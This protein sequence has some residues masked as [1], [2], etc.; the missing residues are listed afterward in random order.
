MFIIISTATSLLAGNLQNGD[1]EKMKADNLRNSG[2]V[3]SP[4]MLVFGPDVI[5]NNLT[6][7]QSDVKIATAF[8]GWIYA[9]YTCNYGTTGAGIHLMK[10]TDHGQTWTDILSYSGDYYR[11]G[12]A[13][14]GND[15]N[16]MNVYLSSVL[17][18]P[19]SGNYVFWVDQND[20][21]GSFIGAR[22]HEISTDTIYDIAIA[23][24]FLHPAFG[25]APY[26]VDAIFSKGGVSQDS[27]ISCLSTDG[28]VTF[29][30]R[31]VVDVTSTAK[32]GKLDISYG[33]SPVWN[34]GRYFTAYEEKASGA[35]EGH[36]KESRT[37]SM[38]TD[39]FSTPVY[40]DS[41][42][43]TVAYW[44]N[45]G[46][47]PRISVQNSAATNDSSGLTAVVLWESDYQGNGTDLDIVGAYSFQA[48]GG[49]WNY[50]YVEYSTQITTQPGI[51]YDETNNNF[52][53]TFW[54]N[55]NGTLPYYVQNFNFTATSPTVWTLINSGYN[56]QVGSLSNPYPQ[57][58]IDPTFTQA[59][60][61]W[62]E[63]RGSYSL[64]L[65]DAE[66]S[67]VGIQNP[68]SNQSGSLENYPNPANDF[69]FISFNLEKSQ[70][71]SLEVFD[72]IGNKVAVL[73]NDRVSEGK[74][75]L[76]MDVRQLP[77]G[78][79]IYTL[80]AGNIQ[81]SKKLIVVH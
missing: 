62:I 73:E 42:F 13:V 20:A 1:K 30:G 67:F 34:N 17:H 48:V 19:S 63:V 65:F 3:K 49:T 68:H 51:S 57:V 29:S 45:H 31:Q 15:T 72:L 23:H 16:T 77:A 52:L 54:H 44:A 33:Y 70:Q 64:A 56:D 27:I 36:I 12:L 53:V 35:S 9:A 81:Q 55:T 41:V 58:V 10:S 46:Y 59:N 74:H 79:Y 76:K 38:I 5:I 40:V 75:T 60:F 4:S 18:T 32:F 6:Q 37:S 11:V 8:N 61:A 69:T 25:S 71:V 2:P 22:V 28:G 80:K 78:Y 66:N 21:N 24:D 7:Q 14:C 50:C 39:V 26:S 47:N 43:T